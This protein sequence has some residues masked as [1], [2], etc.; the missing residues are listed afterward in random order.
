MF[1]GVCESID[2]P[3][4]FAVVSLSSVQLSRSVV[5]DSSGLTGASEFS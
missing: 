1:V 4:S 3:G 2:Q 5:S